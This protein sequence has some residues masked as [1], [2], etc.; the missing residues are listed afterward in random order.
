MKGRALSHLM[1]GLMHRYMDQ[2]P[3]GGGGGGGG[4]NPPAPAP[5][6]APR[7]PETF[8][9]DYVRELR[10]ESAG[11]R[12]KYQETEAAKKAA[13]EAAAK[14]ATDADAKVKAAQEAADQRIIRAELKAAA[15]KAGMVDLDGLKLADLSGVNLNEA[16][17]VEGAEALME[18]LKKSKPYLFGAP[19]SSTPGTPP[20]PKTPEAKKA[21]EMTDEEYQQAKAA[22]LRGG[23]R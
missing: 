13:E 1:R 11:Y 12:L 5:A 3:P 22:L 14:A 8:S 4:N 15:I 21:T 2:D 18:A 17:E 19:S 23:R 7:D 6:P 9:K 16:G 10:N 20:S